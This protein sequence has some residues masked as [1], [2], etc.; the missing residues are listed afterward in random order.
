[1]LHRNLFVIDHADHVLVSFRIG[2]VIRHK[3]PITIEFVENYIGTSDMVCVRMGQYRIV[4]FRDS[5][6]FQI[7]LNQGSFVI[8]TGINDHSMII[9]CKNHTVTLTD[10][11]KMNGQI[12]RI[13]GQIGL[14]VL[15]D[16]LCRLRCSVTDGSD[17]II[18]KGIT[19]STEKQNCDG[20][21]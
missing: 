1:M 5:K 12:A 6:I 10:V 4:Q 11:Y 7:R 19:G 17:P 8:V 3:Y 9:L 13:C 15:I 21:Q 16:A 2:A 14:C 18:S 20:T